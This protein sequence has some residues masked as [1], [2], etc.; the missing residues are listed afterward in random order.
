MRIQCCILPSSSALSAAPCI[1]T[2]NQ[3]PP[4]LASQPTYLSSRPP[5]RSDQSCFNLRPVKPTRPDETGYPTDMSTYRPPGNLAACFFIRKM[6]E[7]SG[8]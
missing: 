2:Y 1:C 3:L 5:H 8:D 4:T 7:I 6:S